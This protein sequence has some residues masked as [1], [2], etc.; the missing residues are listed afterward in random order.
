MTPLQIKIAV[1]GGAALLLWLLGR[2][3]TTTAA[4]STTQSGRVTQTLDI[5]AD[6]YSP[7]FGKPY[8]AGPGGPGG[9]T[10]G[11]ANPA[12]DQT[13]R[14]LIDRSNAAIAADNAANG[15]TVGLN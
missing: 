3:A 9:A 15:S 10:P 14:L 13:M 11:P 7:D 12:Q 8:V 6:V 4:A 2:S 1:Y 5:N